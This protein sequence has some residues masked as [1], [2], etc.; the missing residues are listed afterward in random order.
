MKTQTFA[1]GRKT[2]DQVLEKRTRGYLVVRSD[3]ELA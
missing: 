3:D 1:P 2:A